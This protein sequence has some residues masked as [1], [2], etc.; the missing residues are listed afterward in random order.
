MPLVDLVTPWLHSLDP[1]AHPDNEF[2]QRWHTV[3]EAVRQQRAPTESRIRPPEALTGL[4]SRAAD[5]SLHQQL[6]DA[7]DK[8]AGMGVAPAH[9]IVLLATAEPG[10]AFEAFP[11]IPNHWLVLFMD[12]ITDPDDLMIAFAGG[13]VAAARW[14]DGN[15]GRLGELA[16]HAPWQRWEATRHVPLAEWIYTAGL[17]LHAAQALL[18]KRPLNALLGI[19]PG[20][21]RRLR[22]RERQLMSLLDD[23]LQLSGIGPVMRWLSDDAPMAMRRTASGTTPV[24]AGRYLAYRMLAERVERVGIGEAIGMRV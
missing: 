11:A 5:P 19:T 24:G 9:D 8:L 18:P 23:D 7:R 15:A 20:T 4:M 12:R 13:A 3:L 17:G 1:T 2:E 21:L 6:R 10:D 14:S 22:E 16:R